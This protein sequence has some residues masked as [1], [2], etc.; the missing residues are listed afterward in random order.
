[1]KTL[2]DNFGAFQSVMAQYVQTQ[3]NSSAPAPAPTPSATSPPRGTPRV[4]N[5][6]RFNG[7][8]EEVEPFLNEIEDC[9]YIQRHALP[10]E[11]D[12][13]CN[14]FSRHALPTTEEDNIIQLALLGMDD[15]E[16]GPLDD[17]ATWWAKVGAAEEEHTECPRIFSVGV[18]AAPARGVQAQLRWELTDKLC[19]APQDLADAPQWYSEEEGQRKTEE[20]AR[21]KVTMEEVPYASQAREYCR[22]SSNG[23]EHGECTTP[24]RCNKFGNWKVRY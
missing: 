3:A 13:C 6:R 7:K 10:T 11:E 22:P 17:M 19:N 4:R 8:V 1:M 18:G 15:K 14:P 20:A 9:V 12:K 2:T 16:L 21:R 23:N 24:G 5:P